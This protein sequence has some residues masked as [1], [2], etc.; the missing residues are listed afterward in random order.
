MTKINTA[1]AKDLQEMMDGWNII[2][3]AVKIEFPN[4]SEEEIFHNASSAMQYALGLDCLYN[5]T[6]GH[7]PNF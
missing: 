1:A 2:F 3:T 4:A 6:Q 5:G 7:K